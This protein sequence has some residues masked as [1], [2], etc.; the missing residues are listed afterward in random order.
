M[1]R[2]PCPSLPP[3][4]VQ[5]PMGWGSSSGCVLRPGGTSRGY[6]AISY[7]HLW[8][9]RRC[10]RP[11]W[12]STGSG[13]PSH[14]CGTETAGV[15]PPVSRTYHTDASLQGWGGYSDRLVQGP[16]SPPRCGIVTS[17]SG[18]D[19]C[20]LNPPPA[21]PKARQPHSGCSLQ[22]D[23]RGMSAAGGGSRST[24]LN[25]VVLAFMR[26]LWV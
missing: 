16:G 1:G 12:T 7:S 25:H 2:R 21:F 24:P 3:R 13:N 23:S 11:S 6:K 17:T 20:L 18:V 9:P 19:G 5:S 26:F 22:P 15:P 14:K 8:F 4:A 10:G